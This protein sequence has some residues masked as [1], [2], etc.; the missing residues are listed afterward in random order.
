MKFKDLTGM[1]FSRWTVIEQGISKNKTTYWK[2]QC[3]CGTFK[4]VESCSLRRGNSK[5]CGCF[6]VDEVKARNAKYGRHKHAVYDT[7]CGMKKRCLNE[8][9]KSFNDYGGRGIDLCQEWIDSFEAFFNHIG[10]RPSAQHSIDRIDNN[11]GYEPGNVRWATRI[12]QNNNKRSNIIIEFKG[13]TKTVAEWGRIFNIN[14][15]IIQKR[16]KRGWSIE[17]TLTIKENEIN[18][19]TYPHRFIEYNGISKTLTEWS[20]YMGIKVTTIAERINRGW[21]VEDAF[22]KPVGSVRS[23]ARI[24]EYNGIS[25]S[26]MVWSQQTGISISTLCNRI[27]ILGWPIDKALTMPVNQVKT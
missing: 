1:V 16:L 4:Y 10:E 24:L 9:N 26:V 3:S 27:Y 7:W 17:D 8:S 23:N 2:C 14:P 25:Q 5:S 20:T 18:I 22:N 13:G 12:V 6:A 11:K 15:S 21:T 19:K